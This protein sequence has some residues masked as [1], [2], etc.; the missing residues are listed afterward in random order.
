MKVHY[1]SWNL[2]APNFVD[3]KI[4]SSQ[5]CIADQNKQNDENS[6]ATSGRDSLE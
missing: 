5:Q 4:S 2:K 1:L 6:N 3:T